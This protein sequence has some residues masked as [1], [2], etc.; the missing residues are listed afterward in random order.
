MLTSEKIEASSGKA[1]VSLQVDLLDGAFAGVSFGVMTYDGVL[2]DGYVSL[3]P[4]GLEHTNEGD[5]KDGIDKCLRKLEQK[6]SSDYEI[7][8]NEPPTME[9]HEPIIEENNE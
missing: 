6:I 2:Q 7:T 5:H 1:K 8:F 9:E 3:T 4:Y